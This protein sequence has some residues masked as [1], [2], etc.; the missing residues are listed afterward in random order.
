MIWITGDQH[1]GHARIIELC[2]RPFRD[3]AE[4][5]E[6]L[7]ANY[8]AVV[9]PDDEVYFLGDVAWKDVI[10][11]TNILRHRLN[12]SKRYLL[13]GNHDHKNIRD[14]MFASCF[15]WIKDYHE[16]TYNKQLYVMSHYPFHSWRNSNR[17]SFCCHGHTHSKIDN[18]QHYRMDCGVDNPL[19]GF[20]PISIEAIEALMKAKQVEAKW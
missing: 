17:A 20:A 3:V 1:W 18:S 13:I 19:C 10:A 12:Q 11:A 2:N 16:L 5:N 14:P 7:I 8:N 6:M 9:G 15:E 4:M